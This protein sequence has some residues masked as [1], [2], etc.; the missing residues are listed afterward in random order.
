MP[1]FSSRL[2]FTWDRI[3]EKIE[4][5]KSEKNMPDE[6]SFFMGFLVQ[7]RRML[8]Y[9]LPF[10][11]GRIRSHRLHDHERSNH[12]SS[13]SWPTTLLKL[14]APSSLYHHH[15]KKR[16]EGRSFAV[17]LT[18]NSETIMHKEGMCLASKINDRPPS[19]WKP[20]GLSS[21]MY[22]CACVCAFANFIS[23]YD[24]HRRRRQKNWNSSSQS[25]SFFSLLLTHFFRNLHQLG[26]RSDYNKKFCQELPPT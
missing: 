24:I 3:Y 13:W 18:E 6:Y 20:V 7:T 15:R 22:L 23:P 26:T 11:F 5:G 12:S 10:I 21:R 19:S 9:Y 14:R 16:R 2:Y 25:C 17:I 8:W 1:L 4:I